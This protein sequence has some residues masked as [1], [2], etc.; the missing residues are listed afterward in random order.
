MK[1]KFKSLTIITSLTIAS[2]GIIALNNISFAFTESKSEING[3]ILKR[4]FYVESMMKSIL[5][6]L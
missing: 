5:K 4:N 3:D 2:L 1:N 6:R